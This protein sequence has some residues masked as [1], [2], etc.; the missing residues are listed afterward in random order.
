MPLSCR[1]PTTLAIACLALGFGGKARATDVAVCTDVG[2]FTIELF[3]E[4]APLHAANF[5][6]YVD[7][8][9]YNGTVFHRVIEGFVVQGGGVTRTFRSKTTLPPVANEADN[10]LTND[11]GTLSA[12]RTS[13]PDSATSQ[14]YV[15]LENNANLNR[16]GGD[17]GYS[18]FGRVREGM[19]VVDNIA[20]LPTG[21]AGPFSSDVTNPLVAVTSMV[22][23]VPDRY[24]NLTGEDKL[25]A[26][27]ADIDNAVAAEDNAA[28]AMHFNEYRAV[29][30]EL[31]PE[32][33]LTETEVLAAV[34]RTA[35]AHES[36]TEYL[37]VANNTSEEYFR[38]MSLARE[39]EAA[40]TDGSAEAMALQR[41]A[42]LTAECELPSAPT[43]PN[44]TSTT[45]D[46]MV[47]AQ[48]AVQ[49]Y[50]EASTEALECL[51]ELA[52]DDDLSDEDQ[53]LAILAYNYE[54]AN[55]ES[56]AAQWNTQRE[57]FLALQE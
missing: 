8:G 53:A 31:G 30:G 28:A 41:L 10:G 18:V 26:L 24:A 27:R 52:E 20:A 55:Q 7:R 22:R 9:F 46:A 17:A 2:N 21:P 51:E 5:L 33:L 4:Q 48:E 37:R 43:I 39:L 56:L 42:E 3:D 36:V 38:A 54:V 14:F 44:A 23:V 13:D 29:C 25:A 6:E 16:R 35:A 12:A 1:L 40:V 11:R 45:M 49:D 50:I 57:L 34:G 32:M 47:E 15:N 19:P